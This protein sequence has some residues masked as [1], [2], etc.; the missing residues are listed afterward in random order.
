MKQNALNWHPADIQAAIRKAGSNL[1]RIARAHSLHPTTPSKALHEPSYA[2]EQAIAAFLGKSPR[3]I[4]PN[5]YDKAGIPL[6]RNI[7]NRFNGSST[8]KSSQNCISA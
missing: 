6:H 4:W 2:G 3:E 5:R 7:R 8:T 1:S